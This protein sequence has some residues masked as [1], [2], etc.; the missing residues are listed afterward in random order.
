MFTSSYG[1]NNNCMGNLNLNI[2]A[3][4]ACVDFGGTFDT[5]AWQSWP[6]LGLTAGTC[7]NSLMSDKSKIT[8]TG[9]RGCVPTPQ[10][11]EDVCGG[12]AGMGFRACVTH[13][14]DVGCPGAPFTDKVAVVGTDVTPNCSLCSQC[15]NT[16]SG[17]GPASVQFH[18]N[19]TCTDLR[20]SVNATGVCINAGTFTSVN[21]FKYVSAVQNPA[22]TAGT[23]T[24]GPDLVSKQTI[25]CRP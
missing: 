22:C 4:G 3:D 19:S 25:C 9:M 13:A 16:G 24:P 1:N 11:M 7:S 10:C 6:K 2:P 5:A 15:S 14:D 21:H 20:G 17:C 8:T 12:M 23:S 18:G